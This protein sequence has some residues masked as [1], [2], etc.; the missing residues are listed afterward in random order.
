MANINAIFSTLE[1]LGRDLG[2]PIDEE[3]RKILEV[4]VTVHF[5]SFLFFNCFSIFSSFHFTTY[6]YFNFFIVI[7]FIISFHHLFIF[8]FFIQKISTY[9]PHLSPSPPSQSL[10]LPTFCQAYTFEPVWIPDTVYAIAL[11]WKEEIVLRKYIVIDSDVFY[12][13]LFFVILLCFIPFLIS[14]L[15]HRRCHPRWLH[16]HHEKNSTL[17]QRIP[18]NDSI[19]PPVR[20]G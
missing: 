12:C 3:T 6:S 17:Q 4:G 14:P 10:L 11:Q 1:T 5:L 8:Q 20:N 19:C 15:R 9:S 18:I 16:G 2:D 7:I 13:E